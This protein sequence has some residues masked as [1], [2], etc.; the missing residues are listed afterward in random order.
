[1]DPD[2]LLHL[3]IYLLVIMG[4]MPIFLVK[5]HSKWEPEG[6]EVPARPLLASLIVGAPRIFV[7]LS[8]LRPEVSRP[9]WML[10]RERTAPTQ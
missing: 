4:V 9:E 8:P 5:K 10:V 3:S 6:D 7:E 2:E 1:M